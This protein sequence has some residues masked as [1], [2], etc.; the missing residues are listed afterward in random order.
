MNRGK[1]RKE[2]E[3]EKEGEKR[4]RRKSEK[5]REQA[6][7]KRGFLYLIYYKNVACILNYKKLWSFGIW[8]FDIFAYEIGKN[9]N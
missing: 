7:R 8:Y 5:E 3:Y 6:G 1:E 4:N 2:K 9:K